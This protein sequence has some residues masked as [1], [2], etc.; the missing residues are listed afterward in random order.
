MATRRAFSVAVFA[1]F[2]GRVLL[3][4]HKRLRTWLPVGGEIEAGETPLEA[5]A[6]ELKE[7]TGLAGRFEAITD[8]AVEGTP[9]ALIGYEEHPAG[10]KGLHLNFAF[11]AD[12]DVDTVTPNDEFAEWKFVEEA[13]LADLDCPENVRSLARRALHGGSSP[14]VAL[15]RRWLA[16]FNARDLDR[17]LSMYAEDAVHVSP[18]LRARDPASNGEVRG[19]AALRAWWA[20]SM[21][22]LPSLRYEERTVTASDRRVYLEYVR[23]NLG[24][25]PLLVAEL[26]EVGDDGKIHR[27]HVFH[28]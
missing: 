5:A 8:L 9:P 1:R 25:P 26:F 23:E 22:R 21:N 15:A 6:R 7:E 18:K 16:A 4:K 14:L 20:D 12:V 11:V 24:E 3:I 27:S 2:D 10:A 19:K 13:E 28:G 17:L